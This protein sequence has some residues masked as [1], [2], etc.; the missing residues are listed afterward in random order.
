MID[1]VAKAELIA[2]SDKLIEKGTKSATGLCLFL[3]KL[4]VLSALQAAYDLGKKA[5]TRND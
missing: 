2:I 5:S 3:D 4:H 1:P